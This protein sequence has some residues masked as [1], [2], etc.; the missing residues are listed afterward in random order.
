MATLLGPISTSFSAFSSLSW[1]ATTFLIGQ[2]A[3]QPLTPHLTILFGRRNG[4]TCVSLIFLLGTLICGLSNSLW[5]LLAGRTIQGFGGGGLDSIVSF[6]E[7][8]L[9]P[10][11]NRGIT[12]GLSGIVFGVCLSLGGPFGGGI[13]DAIGWRWAFLIQVPMVLICTVATFFLVNIPRPQSHTSPWRR[14]DYIGM[15]TILAAVVLIQLGLNS[16]STSTWRSATVYAPLPTGAACLAAF[17]YWELR[18]AS[19]PLLPLHLFKIR[20]VFFSSLYNFCWA[21]SYFSIQF[22]VPLYLQI[23]GLSTTST[24]LRFVPQACC[25]AAA[26]LATGM[27]VK[28]TGKYWWLN[29]GAQVFNM[30]GAGLLVTLNPYS[31]SWKPFLFLALSGTG[32][33]ISWIT[34]LMGTLA[35][36]SSNQQAE[37][38]GMAY[39]VRGVG[40]TLGLTASTSVFQSVLKTRLEVAFA[41]TAGGERMVEFLRADFTALQ[42]LEPGARLLAQEAF[43]KALSAVFYLCMA[44]FVVGAVCSFCMEEIKIGDE[45]ESGEEETRETE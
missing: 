36:I 5:M 45:P 19:E 8:D 22:Y 25:A 27:L 30:L 38:Q 11:R 34:V 35:A 28:A 29:V 12:E 6:I 42:P 40:T 21:C 26:L 24:G 44:E 16:G 10:L 20:N 18:F 15:V 2:S 14:I 43:E 32:F 31:A 4:L 17:T 41:G 39:V 9:V 33:G 37:V 3:A 1:I 23:Q 13:N 7:A